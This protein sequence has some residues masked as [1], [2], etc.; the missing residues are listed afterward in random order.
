MTEWSTTQ[1]RDLEH[2]AVGFA[3]FLSGLLFIT[4]MENI[5]LQRSVQFPVVSQI[6]DLRIGCLT[7][8]NS[9]ICLQYELRRKAPLIKI[10]PAISDQLGISV[11]C[12]KEGKED[13]KIAEKE[14]NKIKI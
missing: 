5:A 3:F 9:T 12:L 7:K 1:E 11:G 4:N 14:E 6:T 10:E 8:M 2:T 13:K